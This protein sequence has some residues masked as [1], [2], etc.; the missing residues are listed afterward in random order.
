MF[1]TLIRFFACFFV[2]PF[3]QYQSSR[4]GSTVKS[5]RETAKTAADSGD[6]ETAPTAIPW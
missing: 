1:A 3:I 5:M 4:E 2:H 6:Y